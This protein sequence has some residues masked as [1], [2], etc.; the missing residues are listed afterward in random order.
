MNR[1]L[2]SKTRACKP[3]PNPVIFCAALALLA[4]SACGTEDLGAPMQ[5]DPEHSDA[6]RGDVFATATGA[7]DTHEADAEA[8]AEA[9]EDDETM[10]RIRALIAEHVAAGD[11][12]HVEVRRGTRGEEEARVVPTPAEVLDDGVC[13]HEPEDEETPR[14]P[15]VVPEYVPRVASPARAHGRPLGRAALTEIELTETTW[16]T[17]ELPPA[18]LQTLINDY[19]YRCRH[20]ERT[21]DPDCD[22]HPYLAESERLQAEADRAILQERMD[23]MR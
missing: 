13:A 2:Q 23:S 3:L 22:S 6:T 8:D 17:F 11:M 12:P 18:A 16:E 7:L 20:A 15:R 1:R 19:R 21:P 10:E 14:E 4:L 5:G 9:E